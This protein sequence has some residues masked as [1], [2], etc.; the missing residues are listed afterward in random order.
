M[1]EEAKTFLQWVGSKNRL[2]YDLSMRLPQRFIDGEPTI[3]I[4]PFVGGGSMLFYMLSKYSNIVSVKINDINERLIKTYTVVRDKP[5]KL[6]SAIEKLSDRWHSLPIKQRFDMY[7]EVKGLFNTESMDDVTLAARFWFLN[8]T[9]FNG[10]YRENKEGK[11]NVSVRH[12]YNFVLDREN[13]MACSRHLKRVSISTGDYK[14]CLT[15]ITQNTLV[16]LDPPYRPISATSNF[17]SYSSEG[18]G[19]KEQLE[20]KEMVDKIN[21][22]GGRFMLSNSDCPDGFFDRLYGD[23]VIDRVS[24]Q[25]CITCLSTKKFVQEIVVRNYRGTLYDRMRKNEQTGLF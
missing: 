2:L 23:Y 7:N 14:D 25:R 15:E 10:L 1:T 19:D 6:L 11:F 17:N 3:Y 12:G 16:Y 22:A 5:D 4:E 24:I 13:F 20:L 8:R 18:F 9:C 21:E